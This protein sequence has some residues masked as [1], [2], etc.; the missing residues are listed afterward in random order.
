MSNILAT[1]SAVK[2][3]WT[4]SKPVRRWLWA[5]L[6]F[7][8]DAKK[9]ET[10]EGLLGELLDE[11]HKLARALPPADADAAIDKR[12][13]VFR[14]KLKEAKIPDDQADTLV[15]RGALFVKLL[16]TG[17]IGETANLREQVAELEERLEATL[18]KERKARGELETR[19]DALE[20]RLRA[21]MA[22]ALVAVAVAVIALALRGLH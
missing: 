14:S 13:E 16:V 17:P 7:A 12:I 20:R 4:E 22:V 3:L 18:E 5:K 11:A 21:A 8:Q 15:D 9:R 1:F 2:F 19:I 6:P 10:A